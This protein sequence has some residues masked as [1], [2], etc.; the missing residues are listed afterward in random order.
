MRASARALERTFS[1][2]LDWDNIIRRFEGKIFLGSLSQEYSQASSSSFLVKTRIGLIRLCVYSNLSRG[3]Q[4]AIGFSSRL[5][6]QYSRA[7]STK[8]Y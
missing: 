8:E 7:T 1:N 2:K 4:L 5:S 3:W 6:L